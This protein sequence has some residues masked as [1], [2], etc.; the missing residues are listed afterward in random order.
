MTE[1]AWVTVPREPTEEM[2][3][4]FLEAEDASIMMDP[5]GAFEEWPT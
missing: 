4:A 3:A 1:D 2:C 5:F